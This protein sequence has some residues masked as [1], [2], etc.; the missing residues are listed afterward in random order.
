M[1]AVGRDSDIL[2]EY[3]DRSR[4]DVGR[5]LVMPGLINTHTHMPMAMLRGWSEDR[6]LMEWLDHTRE[7]RERYYDRELRELSVQ[8]SLL[9]HIRAGTTTFADMSFFQE[10]HRDQVRSSGLRSVLFESLM[11]WHDPERREPMLEHLGNGTERVVHG[12]AL[13][14]PYTCG[15]EVMEWFSERIVDSTEVPYSI[16]LS[17]TKRELKQIKQE[18][19][20]RPPA[21]LDQYGL[22]T[23]RLL[24]VH[25]VWLNDLERDRLRRRGVGLAHI[26]ESNMKLGSGVAPIQGALEDGMK[27]ALGTDGQASN[28]DQDMFTEMRTAAF[29]QK[30]DQQDPAALPG[31][32]VYRMATEGGGEALGFPW[33]IGRIEA[34]WRADLIVIDFE[35]V[36]LRPIYD[37]IPMILFTINGRDVHSTMVGGDW[38]M[39]NGEVQTMDTDAVFDRIDQKNYEINRLR[40][41][42]SERA[43]E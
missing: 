32:Q 19:G 20:V 3:P 41:Y 25:G 43:D 14:A 9:E 1:E 31:E 7:F 42:A 40:Q 17:E 15:P 29:L 39:R 35:Q 5:D 38:L 24:A 18:Y 2:G 16:H 21:L 26:P 37:L 10:R 34:G 36:Q 22:L 11:D 23:P 8:I 30:V 33:K 28:N 12:A 6:P 4:I 13:H 27:L